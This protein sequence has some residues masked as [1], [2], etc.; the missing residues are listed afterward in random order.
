[1]S[2]AA[3]SLGSLF[4]PAPDNTLS[5]VP[6][7]TTTLPFGDTTGATTTPAATT[8]APTKKV[9]PTPT[10][11]QETSTVT[12][13]GSGT[14][15]PSLSGLP[16]LATSITAIGYLATTSVDSFVASTTVP[17]G[18]RPAVKF[19]IKN[20]GTNATGSWRFSASIPTQTAYLYISDPQQ[21]LLPGESIDY[22]LGFDQSNKGAAQRISISAN[23]D[24]KVI[25]STTNNNGASA[26]VTVLGS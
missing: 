3:V 12:Q 15:T 4:V 22:T 23:Y 14:T 6:T 26:T 11:G 17:N 5:V 1:L 24:N 9:T 13:I 21:S 18:S 2:A 8:T 20:V 10:A 7:A 19:T 25:E 16:D